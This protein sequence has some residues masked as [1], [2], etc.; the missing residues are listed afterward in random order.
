M[1]TDLS[2]ILFQFA[3]EL[4]YNVLKHA[5]ATHAWIHLRTE[6]GALCLQVE[7]NG[8]GFRGSPPDTDKYSGYGLVS[9][10]ER[11]SLLGGHLSLESHA[12]GAHVSLHIPMSFRGARI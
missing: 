2:V 8:K 1:P 12:G 11:L 6:H 4:V 9:I 7:D 5:A 3:R 10:R